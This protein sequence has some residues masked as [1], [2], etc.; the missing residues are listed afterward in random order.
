MYRQD[1]V[2]IFIIGFISLLA[3]LSFSK[4]LPND[5]ISTIRQRVLQ[6]M[7]W[8]TGDNISETIENA[9]MYN[10]TL[11]SSCYWPD[12]NYYDKGI[13]VWLT[14][15][16]MYRI[17]TMLQALTMNDSTIKNN[18]EIL[19]SV[20]CALNVWL[21]ND[22]KHPYLWNNRIGIPL[23][24][25]TQLLLLGS[26]ATDFEK[27]KIKEISYRADWWNGG[28]QTTGANLVWMIQVELYRSLAT[29]NI[30]GIEQGFEKMWDDV[31]IKPV[32]GQGIQYDWSYHFHG[33][34][35]LSGSYGSAWTRNIILFSLCSDQTPYELDKDK[36]LIIAKLL[37][38]D[39]AW[40]IIGNQWDW[41]TIGRGIDG[42]SAGFNVPFTGNMIRMLMESISLID[43]RTELNNLANRLDGQS[44]ASLLIG[45]KYFYTSDYVVHR[46]NNWVITIKMQSIRTM[47]VECF[48]Q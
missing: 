14:A 28:E 32:G 42:P 19:S 20:H 37:T 25:S 23:L 22:W 17:I 40:M 13:H 16:H 48:D 41:Q 4:S 11:N 47:P 15:D 27:E 1:V 29:N 45:N 31:N 24:S 12:I 26:N 33:T 36:L 44:N 2:F 6:V 43:I 34:L 8:P 38:K 39:D 18:Q 5:D 10:K 35:L 21:V 46:R 7:I 3:R 30:T 9:I